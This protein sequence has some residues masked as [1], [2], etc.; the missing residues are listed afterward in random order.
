MA[1]LIKLK[2]A[3]KCADCGAELPAGSEARYYGRDRVYGV[4]CH[5]QKPTKKRPIN[6][7]LSFAGLLLQKAEIAGL[8][9]LKKCTPVPMIV[10]EHSNILNDKSPVKQEWHVSGGVCGFAWIN[11]KCKDQVSR[12]FINQLKKIGKA[13]NDRDARTL[14]N[15]DSYYGGYTMWVNEGGQSMQR[16]EAYAHAF[17]GVL[18]EAGIYCHAMSRMD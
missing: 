16:K 2:Y 17:A 5:E 15:K 11:V 18:A 4:D 6:G 10:Q 14:W 12:R 7:E 13:S 9:A 1:R 8:V 3:A